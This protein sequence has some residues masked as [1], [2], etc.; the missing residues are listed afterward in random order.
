MFGRTEQF[1]ATARRQEVD[2]K[3]AL[4]RALLE[5]RGLDA[6]VLT[7]ADAV[8]WATGGVTNP[9][10]RGVPTSPLWLVVRG[11]GAAAVTTNVEYPRLDAEAGLR[12]LEIQLHEAP[13]HEPSSLDRAT[14]MLADAAR[15]A[16][17][18]A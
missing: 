4:L 15:A 6:A 10:E 11:D 5:R 9:I 16:A 2:A 1:S 18:G 12:E 13:W 3:L 17:A 7:G 8:A 14:L